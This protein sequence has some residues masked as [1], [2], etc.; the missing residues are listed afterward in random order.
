MK[1]KLYAMDGTV[2]GD[3]ELPE[4]VF[5]VPVNKDLLHQAVT[6]LRARKRRKIA[7]TKTR[8]EVRGGG[9][10]PWAQKGTGRARHG[11]TR[12]PLWRGGGVT[13]GPRKDRNFRVAFPDRMRRKA[14]AT[15]L[16][17][18]ARDGEIV[19]VEGFTLVEPKTKLMVQ[20]IGQLQEKAFGLKNAKRSPRRLKTT[21]VLSGRDEAV[22]R[23]TRNIPNASLTFAQNIDTLQL[24]SAKHLVLH[25]D[26]IP[27]FISRVRV[28]RSSP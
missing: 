22:Q 6:A 27:V 3:I 16:S 12:S 23:A 1:S 25:K 10:K 11:S 14:F 7:H 15:A 17:A 13:F 20:A 4:D 18:K 5:N 19:I 2:V 28:T 26:A 8:A 21:L 24:L 9:R